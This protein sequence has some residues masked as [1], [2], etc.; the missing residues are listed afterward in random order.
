MFVSNQ[1]RQKKTSRVKT[2]R[3]ERSRGLKPTECN[4]GLKPNMFTWASSEA[5]RASR[6]LLSSRHSQLVCPSFF[7][8]LSLFLFFLSFEWLYLKG[9]TGK[10]CQEAGREGQDDTQQKTTG[11][12]WSQAAVVRTR[13]HTVHGRH[14]QPTEL[15]GC[16]AA[17]ISNRCD[18]LHHESGGWSADRETHWH[19]PEPHCRF[20]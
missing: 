2:Y 15:L 18:D 12:N 8:S 10:E 14:A 19:F 3:Y 16:H 6:R 20:I 13:R 17:L 9:R 1:K 11:R 4:M 5:P 7:L